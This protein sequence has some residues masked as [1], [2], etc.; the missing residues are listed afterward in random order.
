MGVPGYGRLTAEKCPPE[1]WV[2]VCDA[3]ADDNS[4][5]PK[6]LLFHHIVFNDLH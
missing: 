4:R 6:T 2:K 3:Y 1:Q 5:C